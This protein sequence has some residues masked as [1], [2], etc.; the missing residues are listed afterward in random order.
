MNPGKTVPPA[1]PP[2]MR[3]DGPAVVAA[4]GLLAALALATA[5]PAATRAAPSNG[6]P[7]NVILMIADGCGFN[8]VALGRMVAGRPLA[9]DSILVG[10]VET[11]SASSRVTAS[12]AA[13]TAL[14][15]GV[16]AGNGMVGRDPSG[17]DVVTLLERARER[18]L[19]TGLVAKS[20]IT[21]AT[22]AAF[23]AHVHNRASEDSVASQE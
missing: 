7:V 2:K 19:A 14:A 21:D 23:A 20:A 11:G 3:A 4:A 5:A 6:R 18:G 16:K 12:G 13:A 17:R 1:A 9:L 15:S 22:P 10:A 8:T